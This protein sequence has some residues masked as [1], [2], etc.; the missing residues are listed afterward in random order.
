[1][2]GSV[3][4]H[5]VIEPPFFCS[6]GC[7]TYFGD[8]VY[9]NYLC[10]ILDNNEVWIGNHVMMGPGV[11][12]YTAAHDL[13]A[14]PRIRGI[15]VAK[16]IAIDDNVWIGG[17]AILMPGVKVGRNAVVGAGAVVTKDVPPNTVV[18]GNPARVIRE[19]EQD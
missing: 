7:N 18:A 6:Y 2:F 19:I 10:V 14:E 5:V 11:Q 8:Y 15:E 9:L 13:R 4:Q 17:S 16:P 3:G 1:M 12:I